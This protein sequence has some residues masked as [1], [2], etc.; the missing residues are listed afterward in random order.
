MADY[1]DGIEEALDSEE[2]ALKDGVEDQALLSTGTVPPEVLEAAYNA[3]VDEN[4][5][6]GFGASP[7]RI[8]T[9]VGKPYEIALTKLALAGV[10]IENAHPSGEIVSS[11]TPIQRIAAN[12]EAITEE[13][14]YEARI[15]HIMDT[16]GI[17]RSDAER[18]I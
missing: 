15:A 9:K 3:A 2:Q 16:R 17:S 10:N 8:A 14:R 1:Y 6:R 7:E 18:M 5:M 12:V 4:R 11:K 13:E